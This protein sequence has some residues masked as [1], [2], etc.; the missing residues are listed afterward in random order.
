M[1]HL[2]PIP[3]PIPYFSN[4]EREHGFEPAQ[5]EGTLPEGLRGTLYRNGVGQMSQFGHRYDHLF[6]GDGAITALR[7]GDGKAWAAHRLIESTGLVEERAA[8]RHLGSFRAGWWERLKRMHRGGLKN[9]ANTS[10]LPWQGGLYALMEGGRPTA[11]DPDTLATL[12][13]TDLG[14]VIPGT[15]SAHPHW[16]GDRLFNF[17]LSYG[18]QTTLDLLELPD[19]G[20][21]RLFGRIP[22]AQPVMLH[23]FAATE[24]HL[25]FFVSPLQ[26]VTW[27]MLLAL[28]PF[29]RAF[30]WTPDAG[31]E[32]IVVPLDAPDAPVRFHVDPFFQF[33]FGGAFED[34]G[35]LCVDYVHYP[36]SEVLWRLGDGLGL[37]LTDPD[38]Q[39]PGG[40]LHRARVD[41]AAKTL[42]SEPRW[43]GECEF[44]LPGPRIDGRHAHT[45]LLS[46]FEQ[47]G[48]MHQ[49]ITRLDE[50]GTVVQHTLPAGHIASEPVPAAESVLTLVYDSFTALSHL[51]VLDAGSLEPQARVLLDQAVPLTFHGSWVPA[52]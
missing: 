41:L 19:V 26:V 22:L 8:G 5:V 31:T 12:G 42:V 3:A 21:A 38:S 20:P 46:E 35:T 52:P 14:G 37:S 25:V 34:R 4:L 50:D 11:F 32:V 28:R 15:F 30:R 6:E 29:D 47:S 2:V 1:A 17:G 39:A 45:W 24:R 27:R 40:V 9:T 18:Q 44:P 13:E 43:D 7:L 51:L 33:H 49:Q 23:D 48:V 10:V 16:V 36:D